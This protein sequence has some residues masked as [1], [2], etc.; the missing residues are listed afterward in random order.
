MPRLGR[1]VPARS[2]IFQRLLGMF[3]QPTRCD[4]RHDPH[5]RCENLTLHTAKP[6]PNSVHASA[7][8]TDCTGVRIV[9]P[10]SL[11]ANGTEPGER[12]DPATGRTAA[13]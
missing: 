11:A 9:T 6:C 10:R 3:V 4:E 12:L 8:A 5:S 13:L 1:D 7:H 2:R